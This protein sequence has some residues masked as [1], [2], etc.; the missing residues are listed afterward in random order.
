MKWRTTDEASV[1]SKVPTPHYREIIWIYPKLAFRFANK[2]STHYSIF[3]WIFSSVPVH[4][5]KIR[6]FSLRPFLFAFPFFLLRTAPI[7]LDW[8]ELEK[9]L[10]PN[11]NWEAAVQRALGTGDSLKE[12]C[13]LL[14]FRCSSATVTH[15]FIILTTSAYFICATS[16]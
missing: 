11:F 2:N 4:E 14:L 12:V 13:C 3:P 5:Q 9:L 16:L 1:W 15:Y 8:K 7:G 6:V 10:N